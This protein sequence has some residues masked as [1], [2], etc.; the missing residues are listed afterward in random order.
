MADRR[1]TRHVKYPC[2][3]PPAWG[4][5]CQTV[6]LS[7]NAIPRV[8]ICSD[9]HDCPPW[10]FS[11]CPMGRHWPYPSTMPGLLARECHTP[12]DP[13]R[14]DLHG[15]DRRIRAP[16]VMPDVGLVTDP[17]GGSPGCR[18]TG[19]PSVAVCGCERTSQPKSEP[20]INVTR[21][22]T[23]IR[24][25]FGLFLGAFLT[26]K[27]LIGRGLWLDNRGLGISGKM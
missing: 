8:P 3:G 16:T 12:W 22:G 19:G 13:E 15:D 23:R 20:T 26:G 7:K 6:S 18:Q 9:H 11:E 17:P 21:V 2:H 24:P 1:G 27:S 5:T 10:A 14:G 4:W 25:F